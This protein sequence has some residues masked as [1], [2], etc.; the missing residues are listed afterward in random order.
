MDLFASR[1]LTATPL[2][3]LVSNHIRENAEE[4]AGKVRETKNIVE[5]QFFFSLSTPL[6]LDASAELEERRNGMKNLD[7]K[8]KGET[9]NENTNIILKV[10]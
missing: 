4:Q 9:F 10:K 8:L 5:V 1:A 7:A 3:H 6:A 2:Q